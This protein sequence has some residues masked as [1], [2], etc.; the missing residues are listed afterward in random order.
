M[1]TLTFFFIALLSG[2]I[3]GA[4]LG[5]I[6]QFVVEPFIDRA[7]NIETQ[8]DI[9]AGQTIDPAQLL[10]YRTWQKSEEVVASIILGTSLGALL[11]IVFVYSRG[12]LPG[13]N[14]I[15]KAVFL[16]GAM[17]FV[18]FFMT[19]LKYP[20][21]PPAVGEPDTLYYRQTLYIAFISISGFSALGLGF[22][23]R[24]LGIII[25]TGSSDS[26]NILST[27]AKNRKIAI[28]AAYAAIMICTYI[29]LPS[30][31]DPI[32]A[33]IDLVIS[34]RIASV[35]T[36]AVYWGTMSIIFGALWDKL[37]PHQEEES[38]R[39]LKVS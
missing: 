1:K 38:T 5:V 37:K 7:V 28:P 25:S 31:P 24:R 36:M 10:H 27:L 11:G 39:T 15:K 30:N 26:I 19:A 33:P 2:A 23:Y 29:G 13:S 9:A 17:W 18:L 4:F 14:N 22:I 12:S 35:F 34:F 21:N 6:N 16:A 20:P 32:T 3:G 8:R